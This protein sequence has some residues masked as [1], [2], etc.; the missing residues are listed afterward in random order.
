MKTRLAGLRAPTLLIWGAQ[1]RIVPITSV[2]PLRAALPDS[3]LLV[4]ADAGHAPF[5]E[6]PEAFNMAAVRFL[7][8][9]A[10]AHPR[11]KA[12]GLRRTGRGHHAG[13]R[14]GAFAPHRFGGA[15]RWRA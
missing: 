2:Q 1:D 3:E 7:R 13:A 11:F 14:G 4:L 15:R 9:P 12:G 8:R 6:Q 10:A 5:E